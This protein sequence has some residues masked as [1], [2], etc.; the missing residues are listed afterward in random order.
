MP[1]ENIRDKLSFLFNNI[2]MANVK[3]KVTEFKDLL[4]GEESE[5]YMRWI[6]EYIVLK[7]AGLEHNFH[8]LYFVFMQV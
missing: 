3:D 2:S 6:S 1:P 7:R 8:P 4:K 5:Q